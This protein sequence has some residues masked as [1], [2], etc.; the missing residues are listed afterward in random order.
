MRARAPGKL[1]VS[2]AYS[3]LRGAPAIVT[4]VDRF[5]YA[6]TDAPADFESAEVLAFLAEFPEARR[7]AHP[8]LEADALRQKIGHQTQKLGLGSSAALLCAAIAAVVA[9]VEKRVCTAEELFER[10]LKAHRL[11]QGGGSGIDVA[12]AAFGGSR[13]YSLPTRGAPVSSPLAL[14]EGLAIEVWA[15]P[16]PA[17]TS[18]FVKRVFALEQTEPRRFES[19]LAAQ[20]DASEAALGAAEHASA[21]EFIRALDA[22]TNALRALGEQ[23][24]VPIVLPELDQLRP[25]LPAEAAWLPSGAGGGDVTL[26]VALE[27]SPAS[28]RTRAAES[29]LTLLDLKLGAPGAAL[30]DGANR[31]DTG[32]GGLS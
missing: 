32:D 18:Q 21:Y 11:A 14:P 12:A 2:G 24:Q 25:W 17:S 6:S 9:D 1:V 19:L 16:E 15:M 7:P 28:F 22:Q 3:V 13:R 30:L 10:G 29:G 27:P 8:Y 20:R 31:P 4:A 23:A 5:A 26:Y